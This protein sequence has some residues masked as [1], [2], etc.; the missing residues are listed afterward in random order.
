MFEKNE[1]SSTDHDKVKSVPHHEK[2][3]VSNFEVQFLL[4]SLKFLSIFSLQLEMRKVWIR[5][6][7][8]DALSLTRH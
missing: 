8:K 7:S 1:N 3:T 6:A 5:V 4:F 2:E